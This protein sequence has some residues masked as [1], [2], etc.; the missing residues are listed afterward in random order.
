[1]AL[2]IIISRYLI[3]GIDYLQIEKPDNKSQTKEDRKNNKYI[4]SVIVKTHLFF[5][6]KKL[7]QNDYRRGKGRA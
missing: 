2:R 3:G 7:T 1:M 6:D 5:E 4:L